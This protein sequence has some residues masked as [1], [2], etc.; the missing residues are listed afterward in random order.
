MFGIKTVLN[1]AR[2]RY[3]RRRH[4]GENGTTLGDYLI[5]T[6]NI[7]I[8]RGTYG[9]ISVLTSGRSP[10]VTN[11]SFC[12]IARDVTFVTGDEH[13]TDR[14]STYPFKVMFLG[15]AKAEAL[16]KGGIVVE[17]DVWIGYGATILD[18]VRIHRGSSLP[19]PSLRRMCLPTLLLA[20]CPR[21]L[22]ARGSMRRRSRRSVPSITKK[23][24]RGS[25]NT[26][27]IFSMRPSAA[28]P[29]AN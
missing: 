16:S 19:E 23:W 7:S 18:G 11:G 10:K 13:P 14:F 26:A 15:D 21:S 25:S 9:P 2:A 3:S 1:L 5:G 4:N 28:M 17:D 8:G 29:W 6:D 12:S 24:T 27:S 22:Y 20:A